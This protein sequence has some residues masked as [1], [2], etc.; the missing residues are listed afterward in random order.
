MVPV[1][2]LKALQVKK[3]VR[4]FSFFLFDIK[5]TVTLNAQ[6]YLEASHTQ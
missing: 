1:K 2:S 6:G 4:F 3:G 5:Q